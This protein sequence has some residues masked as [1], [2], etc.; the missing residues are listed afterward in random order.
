VVSHTDEWGF[1]EERLFDE[2]LVR[3]AA[4]AY[5]RFAG[6]AGQTDLAGKALDKA[7]WVYFA[8]LNDYDRAIPLCQRIAQQW[9]RSEYHLRAEWRLGMMYYNR[10]GRLLDARYEAVERPADLLAAKAHFE[11]VLTGWPNSTEAQFARAALLRIALGVG[12]AVPLAIDR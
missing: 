6:W 5:E 3:Q 11:G 2:E 9:P 12:E 1:P 4:Q 7:A 10:E 8:C